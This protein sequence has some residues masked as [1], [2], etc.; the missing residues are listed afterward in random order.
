MNDRYSETAMLAAATMVDG[1]LA[2]A[3]LDQSVEQLPARHRIGVRAYHAYTQAS[4]MANGRYWLIPLGIGGPV[5]RIAAAAWARHA[6][7]A[8]SRPH[9]IDVAAALSVAHLLSTMK[10][11]GINWSLGPWQ[12][13]ERQITE[14]AELKNVFSR[15]E[16]WQALRAGL[17]LATF[18]AGVWALAAHAQTQGRGAL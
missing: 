7:G 1:L 8:I 16:R 9:W 5:L 18:A 17:Q 4:H 15:F 3:S 14:E 12:P 11:G 13:P 2:G 10:A 6:R